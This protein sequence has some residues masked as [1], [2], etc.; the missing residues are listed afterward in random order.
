[1]KNKQL[2]KLA[3][4]LTFK[5]DIYSDSGRIYGFENKFIVKDGKLFH[6]TK[7]LNPCRLFDGNGQQI[8][9]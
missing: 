6:G 8:T 3:K 9:C 7:E 5:A 2:N 1:M 4:Y